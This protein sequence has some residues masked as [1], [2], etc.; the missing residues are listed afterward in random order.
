[1]PIK[2]N[3]IKSNNIKTPI[4]TAKFFDEDLTGTGGARGVLCADNNPCNINHKPVLSTT[5]ITCKKKSYTNGDTQIKQYPL[6]V[7]NTDAWYSI[8]SVPVPDIKTL[9][10][11]AE[12]GSK[13]VYVDMVINSIITE[14]RIDA[15][16]KVTSKTFSACYQMF[17]YVMDD[18]ISVPTN[19]HLRSSR[20]Y[21]QKTSDIVNEFFNACPICCNNNTTA[22]IYNDYL[23]AEFYTV[24]PCADLKEITDTLAANGASIQTANVV[25]FFANYSVYDAVIKRSEEWQT[26][27]DTT[28][29]LLVSNC[30]N[31]NSTTFS[32]QV[33]YNRIIAATLRHIES[34]KIPLDI[35]KKIY[36]LL[37]TNFNADELTAFCKHNL[38]LL[39]ADTLNHL[40]ANKA[41][42]NHI[43]A[44]AATGLASPYYSSEQRVAIESKEPLIL[45]QAGAGTGKS[46]VILG[47]IDYMCKAGINP[48][49]IT[50]ISF[51]N[52]AADNITEKNPHVH[53]MTISKMIHLIYSKNYP[54]HELSSIDTIINSL[55]IYFKH[56]DAVPARFRHYLVELRKN[57]S[58]TDLNNFVEENFD[59][60]IKILDTIGQTSLELESIIAYHKIDT[61]IEPPEVQSKFLIIDEVQDNSIFDFIYTLKYVDKHNESLFIVGDCSQTLYEFRA[62]N[63]RTLNI[64]EAS[65]VFA[66]Y[67]LQINYRSNQEILDFAN[68]ALKDIEANQYANIQL[69][70]NSL[71]TVTE[72]SFKD[73]VQLT[74]K[75]LPKISEFNEALGPTLSSSCFSYIRSKLAAG[76]Q[77]AF[78]AYTRQTVS[79]I[80]DSLRTLFPNH[81]CVS[82]VP[83][84]IYNSTVFSEYIKKYWNTVQFMLPCNNIINCI[85][86]DIYNKLCYIVR[87]ADRSLGFVQT[88]VMEWGRQSDALLQSYHNKYRVGAITMNEFLDEVR[89]NM[90]DYEIKHNAIK[91][92]LLS[93][94]NQ[95]AKNNTNIQ[96]A[97]FIVSTIHS[98]KGREFDNVIII[99]RNSNSMSEE[100]KRM[101]YVAFT[102]AKKSEYILSFDTVKGCKIE[103]DYETIC[104][105]LHA[106]DQAAQLAAYNASAPN[107]PSPTTPVV[108]SPVNAQPA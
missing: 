13:K 38:N 53:S 83:K 66:A 86:Q 52:A 59:E 102:R 3:D 55:E 76:E 41:I 98:A 91:Q 20:H 9:T 79:R 65:G 108:T 44:A 56:T 12:Q 46:T 33:N 70:A 15:T 62:S 42:L 45:V 48:S 73:A 67:Q 43:P 88:M 103:N 101:Y 39:L 54:Q 6:Y 5:N 2:L 36:N 69:Q 27:I 10:L 49:D 85:A 28:L 14:K 57:N 77:V 64:L 99:H 72:A 93:A 105:M 68:I 11:V 71:A 26:A 96:T 60:V 61:F 78:L 90:L 104:A 40:N 82:L 24:D 47:R 8:T 100:D 81:T 7:L 58:F 74:Y 22:N 92:S 35:Y 50:V 51:T 31:K 16:N 25:N 87:D 30:V 75:R 94:Q 106:K 17:V 19:C 34:Y 107:G 84:K 23:A 97:N 29:Q 80:E 4:Y 32:S 89:K 1:M 95:A 63:P 21:N 37:K 18:S